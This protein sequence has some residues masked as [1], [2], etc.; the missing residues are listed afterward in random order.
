MLYITAEAVTEQ[1]LASK[2]TF[3][4]DEIAF[5]KKQLKKALERYGI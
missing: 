5:Y 3:I 4:K 1:L 2:D